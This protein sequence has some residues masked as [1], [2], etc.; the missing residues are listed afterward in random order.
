MR[1]ITL[2][3]LSFWILFFFG[4]SSKG[5][6]RTAS[7]KGDVTFQK[8]AV[9]PFQIIVPEDQTMNTVRSPIHGTMARSCVSPANAPDVLE[10]LFLDRLKVFSKLMIIPTDKTEGIYRRV[11]A[12]SFKTRPVEVLRRVGKELEVEAVAVGYVYCYRE[13]KGYAYGADKPASVSFEVDLVRVSDG[14][15]FWNAFFDK[16]QTSLMENI[17]EIS[18]FIQEGGKWVTARELVAEG[19]HKTMA[20]FPAAR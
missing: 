16:T 18:S 19:I 11:Q 5:S 8:I 15:V 4:C 7:P 1:Y 20:T 2:I 12:E 9:V 14:V 6:G 3:L 17:L 10:E 13:R